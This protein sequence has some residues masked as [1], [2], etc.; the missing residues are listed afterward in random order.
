MVPLVSVSMDPYDLSAWP[1]AWE[2]VDNGECCK[3]S[4]GLAMGYT[5]HFIDRHADVNIA[6]VLDTYHNDEYFVAIWND[7]YVLNSYFG[8][9]V[10]SHDVDSYLSVQ[11]SWTIQDVMQ[12]TQKQK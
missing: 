9:V 4:K 6:R 1:S 5:L 2:I 11:E 12:R 10:H 8:D 3:Y 7:Q